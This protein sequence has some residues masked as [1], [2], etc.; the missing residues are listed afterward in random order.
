MKLHPDT[1]RTLA[2]PVWLSIVV[3]S[4]LIAACGALWIGLQQDQ[5]ET[6]TTFVFG[7]RV[8][9]DAPV[10]ELEDHVADIVNSVEFGPVFVRIEARILPLTDDDYDLTISVLENTQSV[11]A[12]EV[13]T[14]RSGEADRVARIIA[15]EMVRFVLEGVD[16]S[17]AQDFEALERDLLPLTEDQARLTRLAG[18]ADPVRT[19]LNL[20]R[21]LGAISSVTDN[22]VVGT[23]Q[24]ELLSQIA[25]IGPIADEFRRNQ[26]L[27]DDLEQQMSNIII[28]RAEIRAA[29]QSVSEEWYRSITPVESTSNVPVAIAMA[30]AAAVPALFAALFLVLLNI[31]RRL[32]SR[33]RKMTPA[34][35]ASAVA[36]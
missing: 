16:S 18:G 5:G 14:D 31:N 2:K 21:E 23:L 20:E 22:Q 11:V 35:D 30:F 26:I 27:V 36:A 29:T 3:L 25:N 28:Q 9:F 32:V 7:N 8:G 12:V 33:D 6:S 1:L 4:M 13:R 10:A 24:G 17:I 15:E 34:P 19:E